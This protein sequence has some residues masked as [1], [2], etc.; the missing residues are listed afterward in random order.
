MAIIT[1]IGAGSVVFSKQVMSD[2]LRYPELAESTIALMDI[3][4]ARLTAA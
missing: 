2:I 4:G 1:F 3:D